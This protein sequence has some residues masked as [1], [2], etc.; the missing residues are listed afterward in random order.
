MCLIAP[1][2]YSLFLLSITSA[3]VDF[4]DKK[5]VISTNIP[6]SSAYEVYI[7]QLIRYSRTG[8]HY[9]DFWTELS[10][11]RKCFSNKEFYS[12][13]FDSNP[14]STALEARTLTIIPPM[15]LN[16]IRIIRIRVA[17]SY[18][19][20]T[21][22]LIYTFKSFKSLLW[23]LDRAQLLTQMLLKQGCVAPRLKSSLQ[24]FSGRHHNLVDRCEISISQMTMDLLFFT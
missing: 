15:R 5:H 1:I 20:P 12:L 4:H 17:A 22:L 19:T 14:R 10:C 11:W 16:R 21:V 13:W 9:Y 23:F 8:A 3:L 24:T 6:A 7:L 18:M 2:I